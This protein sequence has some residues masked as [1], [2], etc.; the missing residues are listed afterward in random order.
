MKGNKKYLQAQ[1]ESNKEIKWNKMKR[2][3]ETK[4]EIHRTA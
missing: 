2:T 1:F 3:T 4:K